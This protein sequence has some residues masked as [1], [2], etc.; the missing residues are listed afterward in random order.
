MKQ[1]SRPLTL[2]LFLCVI[3]LF[4]DESV[5]QR[6]KAPRTVRREIIAT[7]SASSAEPVLPPDVKRRYDTFLS[8]WSTIYQNYYDKNFNGLD[9][10]AIRRE[11][12]P[13]VKAAKTD[14]ELHNLLNAM[15][16]RLARSHLAIIP[17]EVYQTL[18]AVKKAVKARERAGDLKKV[19]EMSTDEDVND[20]D[21]LIDDIDEN[22][23][24]GIGVELTLIDDRFVI[25]RTD[26]NS[27]AEYIGLKRGYV[28]EKVNGVSLSEML[29]R[30]QIYSSSVRS[31]SVKQFVP[32][33]VVS[34]MLN[35]EPD[36][37][38]TVGYLDENDQAKEVRIRRE[39][40]K[41]KAIPI[42]PNLPPQQLSFEARS[43]NEKTGY[44]RFNFFAVPVI[45]RFCKAIGD[46][47]SKDSLIVDLRGNSGGAL[48]TLPAL[49]GMLSSEQVALGTSVYRTRSEP[50]TA[51]SRAKNFKGRIVV[52]VDD[53]T[54]SAAEI[55]AL[56]LRENGRALLVGQHTSGQA[57]PSLINRLPTG[58]TLLY[59]FANYRS[60]AGVYI[61]GAGIEPDQP[62]NAD[63]RSFLAGKD[64]QLDK[65]LAL[66]A[67]PAAFA[68]LKPKKAPVEPAPAIASSLEPPPPAAAKKSS[69]SSVALTLPSAPVAIKRNFAPGFDSESRKYL[70]SYIKTLGG[71]EAFKAINTIAAT[72]SS[73]V[74]IYGASNVFAF[75]IYRDK[76]GRFAE[77]LSSDST[78][79]IREI[80]NGTMHFVQTDFGMDQDLSKVSGIQSDPYSA[81]IDIVTGRRKITSLSYTGSFDREGRKTAVIEGTTEKN[82]EIALAFDIETGLLVNV[83]NGFM[84]T[85]FSDYKKVG[86]ILLPFKIDQSGLLN[87][88]FDEILVNK[89]IDATVFAKKQQCFDKVD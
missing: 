85:S 59:P 65:A 88:R 89:P 43:L 9:W 40:L 7:V 25:T 17:P 62:V 5:A 18:D 74:A 8:V 77:I 70:E 76:D 21:D 84:S 19:I 11:Y 45:E 39:P 16:G 13:K 12:E 3:F 27:A 14:A 31:T 72:G 86:D 61:E 81:L 23:R 4:A 64:P 1:F 78:G 28:L 67:D 87:V 46:F 54:A 63:R 29:T 20:A 73:T 60:A 42:A 2:F 6:K 48:A 75:R 26:D 71:A 22:A 37:Y 80:V 83:T 24:Y 79:E 44:I 33:Y 69:G 32:A 57:L 35:G 56:S 41:D 15:L 38:V 51:T 47:R 53:R 66:V 55:F 68:G 49:A 30:I 58:A 34:L 82:E 50:L 52:L 36:T 10:F